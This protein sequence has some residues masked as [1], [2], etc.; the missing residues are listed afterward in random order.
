MTT[1]ADIGVLGLGVMGRNLAYNMADKGFR[2]AVFNRTAATTEAVMANAGALAE[3]MTGCA[4]PE[5]FIGAIRPPRPL[6][7][8]VKAG[9]PVD[10]QMAALAPMLDGQDILIDAGNANFHDT[11]RRDAEMA[12]RG[13][14]FLGI[15]VSGG[16]DGARY[17]PAIMAGGVRA[18]YDRVADVLTAI[19]ATADGAPCCAY[20]GPD[21]AGHFVKTLHNGIEYADMQIIAEAVH[22]MRRD[23]AMAPA[24]IADVFRRWNDGPLQSY[25]IEITA[26]ILATNDPE[27]GTPMVDLILD[28]AGE[29]GTGRWAA[30]E[31]IDLGVPA[32]TLLEAVAARALSARKALRKDTEA[33]YGPPDPAPAGE[34][35]TIA[36]AQLE[37]AVLA[38]KVAA[39]AQGFEIMAAAS[40]R[41]DWNLP[42]GEI[43]RIWRAGCII[44]SRFLNQ[45]A[46]AFDS[47]G[48]L[49]N[50]IVHPAFVE[51]VRNV[52][53]DLAGVVARAAARATPAPALSSALAYLD[54]YR[55]ARGSADL[56]QA[57]RD[58]F[59]AHTFE[60][61]DRPGTHHFRWTGDQTWE[62]S[63]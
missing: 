37:G 62:S 21:G 5:E 30:V 23:L 10:E 43:A 53:P 59:G 26:D 54:G 4:T 17:G 57:Q 39:Y 49:P 8:M 7:L 14:G 61:V 24:D 63:Q 19:A 16:E 6:V 2:V 29:K 20:V 27:T 47:R 25:L 51:I 34:D 9:A 31:S 3:R 55:R 40:G 41:Y 58:Y 33:I 35:R 15:G 52:R 1:Q 36:L 56:L 22:I 18:G 45:I 13:L 32:P 38:G 46:E 60:R 44:R 50:L 42:L 48:D 12:E 11:Q 28:K